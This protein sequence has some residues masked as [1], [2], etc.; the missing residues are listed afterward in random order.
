ETRGLIIPADDRHLT[1]HLRTR[2]A[3]QTRLNLNVLGEAILSD[4]EA[5]QRIERVIATLR[6]PDVDYISVKISAVCALLDVY[7]FDHSLERICA[8]LR[9]I[10]GAAL[11]ADPPSFVNLDMEEYADLDLT[12]EAFLRV[13]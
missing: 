9:R 13:I 11:A 1:R 4:A 12:V 5:E 6:R 8:A 7:A 2:A 10:Y 3:E